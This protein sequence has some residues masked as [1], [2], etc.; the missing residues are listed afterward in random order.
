MNSGQANKN[1]L[2]SFQ[3]RK[4][5]AQ[6]EADTIKK[7]FFGPHLRILGVSGSMR[8]AADSAA[9]N[10][11]SEW[12][13]DKAL[14]E[15]KIMGAETRKI[16]LREF[17]IEPC[18]ACY[19]TCNAQ[20]HFKCD[21]YPQGPQ[22][23][24][25]TNKLYDMVTWADAIIFATPVN[26][27]KISSL[28]ALFIDRLIS[29]D[30]SLAAAAPEN[31]KD[32]KINTDHTKFIESNAEGKFGSGFLKRFTGKVAGIITTGHEE[33]ASMAISQLF[34]TLNHYGM[35]FPPFSNM[36]AI[37]TVCEGTYKDKPVVNS[38]AYEK[39]ARMVANNVI[40]ASRLAKSK[41]DYWWK[42]DDSAN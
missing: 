41:K 31:P 3:K 26:N 39:E 27:F 24:D 8:S 5:E 23:D 4:L 36:Y 37:N 38:A 19:S 6:A 1:L 10:S 30:G 9:E 40:T 15:A 11:N 17:R 33:G 2:A 12:L 7:N 25:M 35:L 21:C 18:K 42:Y 28:M 22:G 20:C 16:P 34:M 14:D 29:M 13:L 32:K